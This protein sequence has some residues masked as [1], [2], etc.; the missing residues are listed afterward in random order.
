MVAWCP[1][2]S[3]RSRRSTASGMTSGD[4][5]PQRSKPLERARSLTIDEFN[6]FEMERDG[7]TQEQAQ[8]LQQALLCVL[9]LVETSPV[10]LDPNRRR[11]PP[12]KLIE[13]G[14]TTEAFESCCRAAGLR[15]F[16]AVWDADNH[17]MQIRG[18][19]D[20]N[21]DVGKQDVVFAVMLGEIAERNGAGAS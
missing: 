14:F 1:S 5:M 13:T 19:P 11:S 3:Q 2:A 8:R 20:R 9:A 18:C 10:A 16:R 4:V 12:E 17:R 21:T 7:A 15:H 6:I